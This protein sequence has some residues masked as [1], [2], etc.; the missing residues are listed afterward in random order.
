MLFVPWFDQAL[1]CLVAF[2]GWFALRALKAANSRRAVLWSLGCGAAA[3]TATFSSFGAAPMIVT[4]WLIAIAAA[5]G[6]RVTWARIGLPTSAA[7][8]AFAAWWVGPI[9]YGYHP[10]DVMMTG[11]R[12][13][14]E[15]WTM[16]RTREL[17]W[18]YNL[19]DFGMFAGWP[20]IATLAL[21]AGQI[22]R[23]MVSTRLMLVAGAGAL[24]VLDAADVTRGEVGRLWMPLLAL[25]LP[26]A[27]A[28]ITPVPIPGSDA[29]R[30]DDV[31]LVVLVALQ[32]AICLTIR[33][34]WDV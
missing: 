18:R 4:V 3:G 19:L 16:T 17:W 33:L 24:F 23:A 30:G 25:L 6:D 10:L 13:H 32:A 1:T 29:R 11:L 22:P 26:L 14:R 8:V 28:A 15:D 2:A 34:S 5:A 31:R 21:R 20:L 7:L 9:L 12:L 27:V